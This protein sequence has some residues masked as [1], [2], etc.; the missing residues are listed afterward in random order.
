MH[1]S[2]ILRLCLIA[3]GLTLYL[4]AHA[5]PT[6]GVRA[7]G[8]EAAQDCGRCFRIRIARG[9]EGDEPRPAL[10]GERFEAPFDT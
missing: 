5:D 8:G 6:V 9:D 2:F 4:P 1:P 7:G 10:F 3:L